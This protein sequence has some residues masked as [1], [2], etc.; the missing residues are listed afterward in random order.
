MYTA[1]RSTS[2]T[3]KKLLD[4]QLAMRGLSSIVSLSTPTEMD[5]SN[6]SGLSVW[7]Y[8]VVRD[9][10]RLNDPSIRS[11]STHELKAPLPT[12][13][14]YLITPLGL[15]PEVEQELLGVVLQVFHDRP[16]LSGSD[17][18]IDL[19]GS[20][21]E[22]TVRLE[23]LTLEEMSRAWEALQSPYQLSLSY[24]VSVVPIEST[25]SST[26][27]PVTMVITDAELIVTADS[28][29]TA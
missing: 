19:V 23:Q 26:G 27:A 17:L 5:K 6:T 13:L 15:T 11:D 4:D 2:K 16:K 24:E 9:E 21:E 12:R 20:V 25:V 10:N 3:L 22:L 29:V 28:L 1:L 7:L 14:H 18:D 8:R